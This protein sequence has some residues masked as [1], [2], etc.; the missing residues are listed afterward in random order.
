MKRFLVILFIF[1][2][3]FAC[4]GKV[5]NDSPETAYQ[6]L[7]ASYEARDTASFVKLLTPS[8]RAGIEEIIAP[9]REAYL[10]MEGQGN[11][12]RAFAMWAEK[13]GVPGKKLGTLTVEDYVNYH[14]Q[15][16]IREEGRGADVDLFP[17]GFLASEQSPAV[18]MVGENKAVLSFSDSED[19]LIFEKTEEG[20]GLEFT[21]ASEPISGFPDESAD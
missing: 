1:N 3:F 15:H 21:F 17:E 20:W 11:A 16:K 10:G 8:S 6:T 18:E 9:I 2:G 7:K 14:M 12:E 19:K 5:S 13:I 4:D